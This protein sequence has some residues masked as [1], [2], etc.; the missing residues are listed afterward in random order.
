M[1][2]LFANSIM[3]FATNYFTLSSIYH[4]HDIIYR[5]LSEPCVYISIHYRNVQGAAGA[6]D[7]G[8]GIPDSSGTLSNRRFGAPAP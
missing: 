8:T 7:F 4:T 1:F 3:L 6:D 2:V 5:V